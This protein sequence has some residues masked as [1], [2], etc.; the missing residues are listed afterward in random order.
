MR[1]FIGSFFSLHVFVVILVMIFQCPHVLMGGVIVLYV[2]CERS[3]AFHRSVCSL[4][5]IGI[6]IIIIITRSYF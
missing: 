2:M 3:T 6:I 5:I 4:F 1:L